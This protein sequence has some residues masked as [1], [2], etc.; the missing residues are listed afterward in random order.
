MPESFQRML[1]ESTLEELL[2]RVSLS[3]EIAERLAKA[4]AEIRK[5]E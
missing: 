1:D 5:G 2:G 3:K 4:L